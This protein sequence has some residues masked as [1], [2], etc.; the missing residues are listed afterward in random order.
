MRA[1]FLSLLVSISM[2]PAA[3]AAER[4][5]EL[6]LAIHGG[7]GTILRKDM[8]PE[9]DAEYRAA[10]NAALDAGWHVLDG[11]GSS[12]D[13][14]EAAILVMEDSPL[15]NAGKG[16]V[17]TCAGTNELDAAIMDGRN[18]NAGAVTGVKAVRNPILLAR[19]VMEESPHVLLSGAGAESWGRA[20]GIDMVD[21]AYFF[22]ERRW[23]A[24]KSV[25]A[26]QGSN[27]C[28]DDAAVLAGDDP[29]AFGTVGAV[30]LDAD[31]NLAAA[32][33]SGG[34]TNKRFGRIGDVPLVGAGTYADNRT[35]A[36]SATG[37]GE[38]FIRAVVAHDIAARMA[39]KG[40]SL[41]SA[42]RAT[43]HDNM[44]KVGDATGT[45]GVIAV[46]ARGNIVF[47][48]NSEGMYRGFIHS[49]GYRGT[50]IYGDEDMQSEPLAD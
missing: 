31:G 33:S 39:Y 15:F 9:R 6:A 43:I 28:I 26:R 37:H 49:S 23:Q 2:L 30:A 24:L 25:Q 1:I 13:A 4:E 7:A 35:A 11:G 19:R 40:D 20:H 8:T 18:R 21:P 3:D 17:F 47:D 27:G 14:V 44:G 45:G 29:R 46:D 12:L 36:I 42:A 41:E 22:T 10:L 5:R 50:A 34:M 38:Y 48:F 32:T 16:A